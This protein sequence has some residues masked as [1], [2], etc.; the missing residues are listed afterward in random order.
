VIAKPDDERRGQISGYHTRRVLPHHWPPGPLNPA[1]QARGISSPRNPPKR[2]INIETEVSP[3][4][5]L[6]QEIAKQEAPLEEERQLQV[7]LERVVAELEALRRDRSRCASNRGL[8]E[9][10]VQLPGRSA[11][12]ES[13]VALVE[14]VRREPSRGASAASRSASALDRSE[15]HPLMRKFYQSPYVAAE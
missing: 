15:L 10:R 6:R 12:R 14:E 8:S 7:Q 3:W 5:E 9:P 11:S 2:E 4:T 1:H 13:S